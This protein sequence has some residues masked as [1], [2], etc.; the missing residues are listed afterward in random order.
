MDKTKQGSRRLLYNH[1]QIN[2]N[3]LLSIIN[4]DVIN[5]H[6]SLYFRLYSKANQYSFKQLPFNFELQDIY[7][8]DI[9]LITEIQILNGEIKNF[10]ESLF[11]NGICQQQANE[12]LTNKQNQINIDNET[13]IDNEAHNDNINNEGSN[14]L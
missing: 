14:G 6:A 13:N 10:T 5:Q 4:G 1:Y 7:T 8:K 2:N 12:Y 9:N 11:E 3:K